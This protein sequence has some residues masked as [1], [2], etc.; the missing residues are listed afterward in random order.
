VVGREPWGDGLVV[1]LDRIDP[2]VR[3]H[4][5]RDAVAYLMCAAGVAALAL[6]G[7]LMIAGY[8]ENRPGASLPGVRSARRA[9][10]YLHRPRTIALLGVLALVLAGACYGV[11]V[12]RGWYLLD[13]GQM[14]AMSPG[15]SRPRT[16][17]PP[18]YLVIETRYAPVSVICIWPDG[19]RKELV[20]V[21]VNT[22]VLLLLLT[23]AGAIVWSRRLARTRPHRPGSGTP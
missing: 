6:T 21:W 11:G 13:P 19:R 10:R 7:W 16:D 15:E 5:V 8:R 22:A 14:C 4:E 23:G 3:E 20:P 1:R 9:R 17:R 2:G 18:E 12:T